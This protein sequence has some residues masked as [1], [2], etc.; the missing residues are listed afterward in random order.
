MKKLSYTACSVLFWEEQNSSNQNSLHKGLERH[1]D[2]LSTHISMRANALNACETNSHITSF[3]PQS[4]QISGM[5]LNNL[6]LLLIF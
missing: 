2:I 1:I 6:L 3:G 5:T 4:V